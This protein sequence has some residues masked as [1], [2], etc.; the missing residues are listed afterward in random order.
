MRIT[1]TRNHYLSKCWFG[2]ALTAKTYFNWSPIY[3]IL[4]KAP[5]TEAVTD[6]QKMKQSTDIKV[7]ITI[8]KS[9]CDECGEN[10]GRGAWI[11]LAK[12]KK[13]LCRHL[14]ERETG[15]C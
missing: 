12:D 11:T 8:S 9:S 15:E 5:K 6:L 14:F 1:G 2:C 13:A 3:L 10:L 4:T 7:F